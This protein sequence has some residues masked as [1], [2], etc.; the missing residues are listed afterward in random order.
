MPGTVRVMPTTLGNLAMVLVFSVLTAPNIQLG[1]WTLVGAAR[2]L[3]SE[4][5]A[6]SLAPWRELVMRFCVDCHGAE[7]RQAGLRFDQLA[8]QIDAETPT[9]LA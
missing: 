9:S 5:P 7:T 8:Y 2:L 4:P 1:G 3:A 6:Q